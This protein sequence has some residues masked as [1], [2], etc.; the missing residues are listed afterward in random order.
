MKNEIIDIKAEEVKEEPKKKKKP[1]TPKAIAKTETKA[2][3]KAKTKKI[4]TRKKVFI[5]NFQAPGDILML[6]AAIRDLYN[7]HKDKYRINVNTT[8]MQI[9]ENNPYLDKEVNE[10]NAD[11]KIRGDYPLVHSSNSKSYHFISGFRKDLE[12]KLGVEIPQGD[13]KPDVHISDEEKSWIPQIQEV[14]GQD[15]K[16]WIVCA[17]TKS[18]FTAKMWEFER[19][20]KVINYFKNKITFVQIGELGHGHPALK[21]VIDLRGKTDTR[22]LIRLVY[23]SCGMLCGV[24]FL[25]HLAAG[26][27]T[28]GDRCFKTRPAVILAGGREPA[29]WEAYPYHRYMNR[30]SALSCCDWGGCWKSR[31]M[32]LDDGDKEKDNSVCL[33]PVKSN[34]GQMIP[35]CMDLISTQD[36]IRAVESYEQGYNFEKKSFKNE[37][38]DL[39]N[40]LYKNPDFDATKNGNDINNC[41]WMEK[42]FPASV[43]GLTKK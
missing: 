33:F 6:V 43:L 11:I 17:G 35:K 25:M 2:L 39:R 19:Y 32:P 16:Y 21:N 38:F 20:Q 7:A 42:I 40:F 28:R 22:Q 1:A 15:L 8:A 26:V 12:K 4:D 27:E 23:H 29:Q 37:G 30:C 14:T 18:D 10:K 36:V 5:T 24:T 41:K 34:S 9:W 31:V 13:F 3:A